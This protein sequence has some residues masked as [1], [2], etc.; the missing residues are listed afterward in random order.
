MTSLHRAPPLS[1]HTTRAAVL[2]GHASAE[3]LE[4][5]LAAIRAHEPVVRAWRELDVDA[6]RALA[7]R[8]VTFAVRAL[9]APVPNTLLSIFLIVFL[10]TRYDS[11]F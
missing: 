7:L 10:S 2:D 8:L 4:P 1:A 9:F 6:A 5:C 3:L 11:L